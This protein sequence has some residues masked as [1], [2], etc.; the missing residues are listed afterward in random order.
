MQ[1]TFVNWVDGVG[2]DLL[3]GREGGSQSFVSWRIAGV[4]DNAGK[5]TITIYPHAYQHL[6][7]AIRWLP[8]VL[9]IQPELR[10]YLQSVVRGFEWYIVTKQSVRKNQFGSHRWFSSEDA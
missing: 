8:Y 6:P 10:K 5:L 7:V 4:G 1:R 3:I 2:Y 9:K